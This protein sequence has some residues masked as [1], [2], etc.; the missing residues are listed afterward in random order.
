MVAPDQRGRAI[1]LYGLCVWSGFTVGPPLGQVAHEL[2]GF[3]AVWLLAAI[4]PAI[5]ALIVSR[6]DPPP[7]SPEHEGRRQLLPRGAIRPG[8]GGGMAGVG[9]AA[10]TGFVVL[11]CIDRGFGQ[12][13]G[14]IAIACFAARDAGRAAGGGRPARPARAAPD[15]GDR[16]R[17]RRSR[18]DADRRRSRLVGGRP[19]L[20]AVRLLLDAAV[21]GAG[22]ARRRRRRAVAARRRA[23]GVLELLRPRLRHRRT[24]AG[25][26]RVALGYGA[27]YVTAAILV[28]CSLVSVVGRRP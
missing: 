17:A 9:I 5:G 4:P 28:V 19:R 20:R 6:L 23:G 22:D 26:D 24:R 14:A 10:I 25:R 12:T 2:G 8:I 7:P 15:D 3:T 11:L 21:P 1:G 27:I 16:R 18:A 13:S